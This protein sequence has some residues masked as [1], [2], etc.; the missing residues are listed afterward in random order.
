MKNE[1]LVTGA[2]G[3]LGRHLVKAL[4]ARGHRVRPHSSAQGDIANCPL[5]IEGVDHVFHLAAKS[6]VPDSWTHSQDFYRTNVVGTVN[7]LDHCRRHRTPVTLISSYVYGQPQRL[8]ISEDHPLSAL[9]PY[10][11]TKILAEEVA[12]FYEQ[13][14]GI[15]LVIVRAFNMYGPGQNPPYLIPKIVQQALDPGVAEIRLKDLRP[16]RDY[17]FV[18]DAVE[19]LLATLGD[20]V[21]GIYNLGSGESASVAE[22]AELICKAAGTRKPIISEEQPRPQEVMDVRADISRAYS[23]LA[24]RPTTS[25]ADG[26]RKTVAAERA[27]RG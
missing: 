13:L 22:V 25:L 27:K 10:G 20:K 16:K 23:D 18:T 7:V 1:I 24:W 26:I 3:F 4:E 6:F 2:S 17:L 15:R 5:P 11:H 9:N 14:F 19:M 8:P 12:R 21:R